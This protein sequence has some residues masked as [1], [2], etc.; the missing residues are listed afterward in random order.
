LA[1]SKQG[2]RLFYNRHQIYNIGKELVFNTAKM[3]D[4]FKAAIVY[5][6]ECILGK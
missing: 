1:A 4:Y 6:T 2:S 3:G 5:N